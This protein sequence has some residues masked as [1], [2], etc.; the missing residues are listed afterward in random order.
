MEGDFCRSVISSHTCLVK[1]PKNERKIFACVFIVVLQRQTEELMWWFLTN[2]REDSFL[3][4]VSTRSRQY[5][6]SASGSMLNEVEGLMF[7]T[8]LTKAHVYNSKWWRMHFGHLKSRG[9]RNDVFFMTHAI[10]RYRT[11]TA[12]LWSDLHRVISCGVWASLKELLRTF[13][14]KFVEKPN[15][16]GLCWNLMKVFVAYVLN[17]IQVGKVPHLENR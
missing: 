15:D 5:G 14:M 6:T 9:F 3:G 13:E 17:K 4:N 16:R 11:S 1:M 10:R 8:R 7:H 12:C 2:E